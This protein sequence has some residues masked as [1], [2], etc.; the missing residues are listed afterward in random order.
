MS[1]AQEQAAIHLLQ[2]TGNYRVLERL[3]APEVYAQ[4]TA[5]TPRI[6]L[7]VDTETTGLNM[8]RDKIIELGFVAFEYDASSGQIYRVLHT[9]DG[10]ED[11]QEPLSD[12]VKKL[13]GI[14]DAMLQGQHLD[15]EEITTWLR[16]ASLVIAH[17]AS[18]DRAMLERR[19]PQVK[20][21]AW[22][23]SFADIDWQ[24]EGVGGRKLDYLA[25][26]MGFFFD[27]HRAVNDAQATLHLLSYPLPTS[28]HLA[29]GHLLQQARKH[30]VRIFALAAPYDKKDMLKERGYRWLADF[31]YAGKKGVWSC[32][33]DEEQLEDEE[34][35]LSSDIYTGKKAA[36]RSQ[37]VTA[38]ERYSRRA[39]MIRD[40]ASAS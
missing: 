25:F 31:Q 37:L 27:G 17:N 38:H 10:F 4:G 28:K 2:S 9:Y 36:F 15:D 24:A 19:L 22:G 11:P 39:L 3:H 29:L 35:W 30:Q 26:C 40:D 1:T 21:C 16:K 20:E 8:Q 5:D 14:D 34:A 23:C 32:C 12:V 13:T 33:L 7:V 6:G 18:F